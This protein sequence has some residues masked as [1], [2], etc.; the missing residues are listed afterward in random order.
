MAPSRVLVVDDQPAQLHFIRRSLEEHWPG[1]V[2]DTA[3]NTHEGL[4][5]LGQAAYD[6]MLTDYDLKDGTG[7]QL[8]QVAHGVL[9]SMPIVMLTAMPRESI[10]HKLRRAR[11]GICLL[12]HKPVDLVLLLQ[13]LET[14]V[15]NEQRSQIYD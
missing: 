13:H 4:S 11:D 10:G 7:L 15:A 9:P 12:L 14:L 1:C 5:C 8:A 2:V 6:L 3:R